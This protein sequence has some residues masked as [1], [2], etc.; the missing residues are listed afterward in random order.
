[1]L[2]HVLLLHHEY[3]NYNNYD[4]VYR[5]NTL[6]INLLIVNY[7]LANKLFR[8]GLKEYWQVLFFI[9]TVPDIVLHYY[10]YAGW[11][12]LLETNLSK[13]SG[14][15]KDTT[16]G[17][18]C[19]KCLILISDS[20]CQT[21]ETLVNTSMRCQSSARKIVSYS[22]DDPVPSTG[23]NV[24]DDPLPNTLLFPN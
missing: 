9:I 20:V 23:G 17:T 4:H 16:F 19:S 8:L 22:G 12:S 6:I 3:K 14:W 7:M 5:H 1:M 18:E 15:L 21:L 2:F 11:S 10:Y 13:I 24:R